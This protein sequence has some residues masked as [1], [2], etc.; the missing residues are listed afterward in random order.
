[1]VEIES[2]D[3]NNEQLIIFDILLKSKICVNSIDIKKQGLEDIFVSEVSK[4]EKN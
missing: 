2:D 3:I 4:N 1:M